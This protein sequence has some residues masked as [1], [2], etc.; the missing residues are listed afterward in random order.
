[1]KI[2][3][4]GATGFIGRHLLEALSLDHEIHVLLRSCSKIDKSTFQNIFYFDGDISVLHSYLKDNEIEGIVHLASLYLSSHKDTDVKNLIDSNIYLGTA[5]LEASV[6]TT[7]KWFLNTGTFWQHY[8][9][10]SREYHPVNLYAATKQ[11]FIDLARYYVEVTG[12]KFVTLKICDTFGP[13]D[14]RT[15]LFNLWDNI[16][17]TGE[18]LS[19]SP[20]DQYINVLYISDVINGFLHLINMLVSNVVLEPDYVLS[21]KEKYTIKELA[22]IFEETTERKLNIIWGGREYR[23]REVMEPWYAGEI[24]PEWVPMIKISEGL[25]YLK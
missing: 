20:G 21:A 25:E 5:L 22:E 1:M 14:T 16:S 2:L 15:K 6:N 4:T 19:M 23:V 24:L 3:V 7:V 17:K 8:I 10:D 13:K 12:I 11:S 9:A 18:I